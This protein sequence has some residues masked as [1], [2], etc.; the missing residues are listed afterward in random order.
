MRDGVSKPSCNAPGHLEPTSV[1]SNR[2]ARRYR[3]RGTR[4]LPNVGGAI[5]RGDHCTIG[6]PLSELTHHE[7]GSAGEV[8]KCST[9]R[10]RGLPMDAIQEER[11]SLSYG[12]AS[13]RYRDRSASVGHRYSMRLLRRDGHPPPP[14]GVAL[15]VESARA[16]GLPHALA[17][18]T[19]RMDR[20]PQ[21]LRERVDHEMRSTPS[22]CGQSPARD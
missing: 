3:E 7:I 2:R 19:M 21:A 17:C 5:E 15:E 20:R 22:T 6:L 13:S 1:L 9:V 11:G 18:V 16:S 10:R 4:L 8:R 14:D 12:S